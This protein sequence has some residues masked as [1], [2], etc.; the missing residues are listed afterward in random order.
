M[1]FLLHGV[2]PYKWFGFIP[3]GCPKR[4]LVCLWNWQTNIVNIFISKN[5]YESTAGNAL[6]S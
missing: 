5:T 3:D 4:T 2:S 1:I 6:K